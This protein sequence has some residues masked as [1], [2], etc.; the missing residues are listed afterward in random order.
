MYSWTAGRD[1]SLLRGADAG[2]FTPR[3]AEDL[4]RVADCCC[5]YFAA[6]AGMMIERC[7]GVS[8]DRASQRREGGGVSD[9]SDLCG[10]GVLGCV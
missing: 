3:A 2:V 7:A 6:S 9:G 10:G 8:G 4:A 1:N 5:Y